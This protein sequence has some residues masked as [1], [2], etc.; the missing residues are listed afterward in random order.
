MEE[1][2]GRLEA[3]DDLDEIE[4]ALGNSFDDANMFSVKP[5]SML[6]AIRSKY[7]P[8]KTDPILYDL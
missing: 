6:G 2:I 3:G 4:A 7:L 1:T 5:K 8:P